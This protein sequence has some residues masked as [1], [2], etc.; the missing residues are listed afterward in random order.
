MTLW[1][2][3]G[4]E[5]RLRLRFLRASV[6]QRHR[7]MTWPFVWSLCLEVDPTNSRYYN[8]LIVNGIVWLTNCILDATSR[9]ASSRR[10]LEQHTTRQLA[11]GQPCGAG[12]TYHTIYQDWFFVTY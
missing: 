3:F 10:P 11:T 12:R 7:P 6:V 5:S 8:H 4:K 1:L 2:S 9:L